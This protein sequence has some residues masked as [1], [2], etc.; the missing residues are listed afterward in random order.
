VKKSCFQDF[1]QKAPASSPR[2]RHGR[3]PNALRRRPLHPPPTAAEVSHRKPAWPTRTAAARQLL[4]PSLQV[5]RGRCGETT[6]AS[7][8]RTELA[9]VRPDSGSPRSDP[10]P[11]RPDPAFPG[12]TYDV[13]L[14]GGWGGGGLRGVSAV[15]S[16]A[17]WPLRAR[18][19]SLAAG[20]G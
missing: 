10:V 2:G 14:Y 13:R 3:S 20:C 1:I 19:R 5:G 12:R 7:P 15:V 16:A 9:L 11:R 6:G 18:A 4:L 17:R 8:R